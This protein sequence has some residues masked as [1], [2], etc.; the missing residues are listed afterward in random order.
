MRTFPG[1]I[2]N[3]EAGDERIAALQRILEIYSYLDPDVGYTQ[4]MNFVLSLPLIYMNDADAFATFYGM[5]QNP[6]IHLRDFFENGLVGFRNL[7]NVW[8][9]LVEKRYNWLWKAMGIDELT[10]IILQC[11]LSVSVSWDIPLELKLVVF[12]RIII[13]GRR[14]LLSFYLGLLRIYSSEL[15]RMPTAE[16]GAW[17]MEMG[18]RTALADYNL[19]IEAWNAEWVSAEEFESLK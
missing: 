15:R 5:M 11:F 16:L 12:D 7:C 2:G 3:Q 19:V 17:L 4:G 10:N 8:H 13:V 18:K 6:I 1:T 14:A 9:R